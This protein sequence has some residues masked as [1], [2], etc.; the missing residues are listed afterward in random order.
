MLS[1]LTAQVEHAL[2]GAAGTLRASTSGG[3]ED[4][5]AGGGETGAAGAGGASRFD[6]AGI[7]ARV[8]DAARASV[9]A[10]AGLEASAAAAACLA[11]GA[12]VDP[13]GGA[14]AACALAAA[15]GAVL[16]WRRFEQKRAFREATARLAK[17]LDAE[18][19][20]RLGREVGQVCARSDVLSCSIAVI[21]PANCPVPTAHLRAPNAPNAAALCSLSAPGAP[22]GGAHR[23]RC[24]PLG[25]L[26]RRRGGQ[27]PRGRR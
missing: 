11:G 3:K 20:Q 14:L 4:G 23:R 8:G 5:G 18:L 27:G 26:R 15:G 21:R 16:P 19:E 12:F 22:R 9:S 2:S 6:P 17:G 13:T 1:K 24:Q 10:V 7:A 25:A